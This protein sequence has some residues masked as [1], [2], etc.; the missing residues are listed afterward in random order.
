MKGKRWAAIKLYTVIPEGL[1]A[2]ADPTCKCRQ[3]SCSAASKSTTWTARLSRRKR[4]Q[5]DRP[6]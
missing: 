3:K 1:G 5:L 2:S 4:C 6:L